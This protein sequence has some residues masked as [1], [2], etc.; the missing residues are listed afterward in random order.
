MQAQVVVVREDRLGLELSPS[1]GLLSRAIKRVSRQV[2]Y[3]NTISN[4]GPMH[5][6]EKLRSKHFN[7]HVGNDHE[8]SLLEK[9]QTSA[10]YRTI[11]TSFF[12]TSVSEGTA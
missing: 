3:S 2:L 6:V 9:C 5:W 11:S 12:R 10:L 4:I 1:L 7:K 8:N